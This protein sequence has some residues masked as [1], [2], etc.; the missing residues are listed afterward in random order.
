MDESWPYFE[1]QVWR[2][3]VTSITPKQ[4]ESLSANVVVQANVDY[5]AFPCMGDLDFWAEPDKRLQ[6]PRIAIWSA[7][8]HG[9]TVT[10]VGTKNGFTLTDGR[11]G[12]RDRN[13]RFEGAE[14]APTSKDGLFAG[15]LTCDDSTVIVSCTRPENNRANTCQDSEPLK[16]CGTLGKNCPTFFQHLATCRLT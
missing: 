16:K 5:A 3:R 6:H 12:V 8:D 4:P 11:G 1:F 10:S 2:V 15:T 9:S 7:V 14:Y 13:C